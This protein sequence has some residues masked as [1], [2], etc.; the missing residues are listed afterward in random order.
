MRTSR[1]ALAALASAGIAWALLVAAAYYE[2]VTPYAEDPTW[3][4]PERGA[5][6]FIMLSPAVFL[7]WWLAAFVAGLVLRSRNALNPRAVALV[8]IAAAVGLGAFLLLL[9]HS[10]EESPLLLVKIFSFVTAAAAAIIGASSV[11]WWRIVRRAL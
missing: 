5:A 7:L 1:L 3:D 8:V 4:A 11:A 6:I 2:M 9:A 10:G